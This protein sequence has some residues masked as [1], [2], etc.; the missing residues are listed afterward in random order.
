MGDLAG[1][2]TLFLA[3]VLA[4]FALALAAGCFFA[5][6]FLALSLLTTLLAGVDFRVDAAFGDFLGAGVFLAAGVALPLDLFVLLEAGVF[7]GVLFGVLGFFVAVLGFLDLI[8]ALASLMSPS[9]L[10]L[11]RLTLSVDLL[12]EGVERVE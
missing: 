11:L 8:P 5:L 4:L 1:V 2:A 3:G 7:A 12:F 10:R 9:I 6:F